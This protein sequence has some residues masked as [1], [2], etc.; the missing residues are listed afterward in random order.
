[1]AIDEF[2]FI[3]KYFANLNAAFDGQARKNG[4]DVGIG[5][6]AALIKFDGTYAV[7][8]DSL[9][10]GVHF[11]SGFNPFLLGS[12]ALEVNFS[13]V[14]AMGS[15]PQFITLA[16]EVPERYIGLD[17][18]WTPF[19]KGI[20]G[21]LKRHKCALIGG[22]ITKYATK[23]APLSMN[24]SAFGKQVDPNARL[25]RSGAKVGDLI[26]CTGSIGGNGI[27]VEAGYNGKLKLLDKDV[28]ASF[29]Q[30][31]YGYD[32]RMHRFVEI[33]V[34][35]CKCAVDVSDGL[36]GDLSHILKHSNCAAKLN[37]HKL[38][39]VKLDKSIKDTLGLD[40]D[41]ILRHGL[42]SGGD[43]NLLFTLRS[44]HEQPFFNELHADAELKGFLVSVIGKIEAKDTAL[45]SSDTNTTSAQNLLS[46]DS[47]L[48]RLVDDDGN[49]LSIDLAA[50]S[51][52]HFTS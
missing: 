35:Y 14:Y 9:I 36:L 37:C 12:R 21:A 38:P 25:L 5:D 45:N 28:F 2:D 51:Y 23:D 30:A 13:D 50:S 15:Q 7:T 4:L 10:E 11:F 42:S 17:E 46:T 40:D 33:L 34:K 20:E 3:H 47:S 19:S 27:Y 41:K 24:I 18:F 22:N 39:L 1:M 26:L 16:L 31:S 44:E 32:E 8:T 52:N 6:D 48:I 43:Y 49:D 29:E